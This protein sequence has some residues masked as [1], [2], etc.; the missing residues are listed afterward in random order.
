MST[1]TTHS[2]GASSQGT[3]AQAASGKKEISSVEKPSAKETVTV[4]QGLPSHGPY[5]DK[6][7]PELYR[8][9]LTPG[10]MLKDIYPDVDLDPSLIEL[11]MVR[12]SQLNRCATCLSVHVPEAR[13]AGVSQRKLD[14]L[15]AWREAGELFSTAERA[16][17]D[18]AET[19]TLLPE[20]QQNSQA[21]VTA[22]QVFAEEQVAALEWAIIRIN[23]FNRISIASGHPPLTY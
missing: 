20:G 12:V 22:C 17:L 7:F 21:A 3:P 19:L 4:G 10:K 5:L 16:A 1:P 6:F 15:P 23:A 9:M 2:S 8:A 11:L 13:K 14:I 18:L